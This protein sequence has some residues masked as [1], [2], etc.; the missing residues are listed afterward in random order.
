MFGSGDGRASS[1]LAEQEY[2]VTD[3]SGASG[4]RAGG[5]VKH[6]Y[7]A[8]ELRRVASHELHIGPGEMWRRSRFP[9]ISEPCPPFTE[10]ASV[11][12]LI[13]PPPCP[14]SAIPALLITR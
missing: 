1:Y 7:A 9:A 14:V 5:L 11:Q 10:T 13:G 8:C 12:F 2:R 3:V 6:A 4:N